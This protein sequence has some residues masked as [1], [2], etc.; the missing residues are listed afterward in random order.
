MTFGRGGQP[1]ASFADMQHA[2]ADLG[3]SMLNVIARLK[4]SEFPDEA[5]AYIGR[6]KL[7]VLMGRRIWNEIAGKTVLDFGCGPGVEAV[8]MAERGAAQVIGVEIREKWLRLAKER[9]DASGVS[10]R[11]VFTRK[12]ESPVDVIVC[13]DCF[14]HFADP[15]AILVEMRRLLKPGGRVLVSFGPPWRH[16]LGGHLYSV[17]PFSHLVFP[18]TALVKWRSRFKTDGARTILESGL[19]K[20]TVGRF[21]KLL[22]E[23]PFEPETLEVVPIRRLRLVANRLTREFTTSVVRCRLVA[24]S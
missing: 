16:P 21:E 23:S 15:A 17:F 14:E 18:D 7:E 24:R 13:V 2:V 5:P 1:I 22:A 6:S 3:A 11:C 12:W 4:I 8:E 10:D 20:M 19:N 9:A